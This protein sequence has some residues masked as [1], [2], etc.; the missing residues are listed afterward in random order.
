MARAIAADPVLASMVV[1][2]ATAPVDG[3][4]V[5]QAP[6]WLSVRPHDLGALTG[7]LAESRALRRTGVSAFHAGDPFRPLRPGGARRVAVTVHDLIPLEAPDPNAR[8]HRQLVYRSYLGSIRRADR[9]VVV[10]RTTAAAVTQRLGVDPARIDVVPPVIEAP[11]TVERDPAGEP[12][13]LFVGVPEAHKQ[14]ALALAALA[15]YRARHGSGRLRFLGPLLRG[16]EAMLRGEAERLGVA[17][18]VS[19]EGRVP[20]A[21]LERAWATATALLAVSRIEGFG[22]PPVE[23][24]LR[25]VPVVA[26]DTSIAR[27]TLGEAATFVP[28][29]AQ[30]LSDGLE[31]AVPPTDVVR[32]AL[33]GRHSPTAVAAALRASYERLLGR[34]AARS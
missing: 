27:E 29:D 15:A 16:H 3:V 34:D 21:E 10:S 28:A 31:R 24:A 13:F 17:D 25:G 5:V 2:L 9:V 18:A 33:A 20:A 30:A 22:L 1:G 8:R 26:C 12:T 14:P 23:A 32:S 7:W 6:A 11:A 4:R 19:V